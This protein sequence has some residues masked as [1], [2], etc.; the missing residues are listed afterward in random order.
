MRIAQNVREVSESKIRRISAMAEGMHDVSRLYFGESNMGT[1]DFIKEAGKRAIDDDHTFYTHNAGYLELRETLSQKIA[2]LRG[3]HYDPHT[4]IALTAGGVMGLFL[5]IFTLLEPGDKAVVISP[6]WPNA[7]AIVETIGATALEVALRAEAEGYVL[8]R[9]E[10]TRAL[11]AGPR[12]IVLSS[13]SNPTGWVA[14]PDDLA[15]LYGQARSRGIA[16]LS[17]EVYDHAPS[18]AVLDKDKST[19]L[20]VNSF[21]K[22]YCM[23]GWRLGYVAGNAE[24]V[25]QIVKLL[26]FTVSHATSITQRAAITALRNGDGFIREMQQEYRRKRDLAYEALASIASLDAKKPRGA[27]YIFPKV[28]GLRD[29]FR[30]AKELLLERGVG[31]APG[32]AF[33]LGGE[34]HIRLCFAVDDDLLLRAASTIRARLEEGR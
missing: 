3:I 10:L 16:V 1:P 28:E 4:E 22:T 2:E 25:A 20:V 12:L 14:T 27:F 31:V 33:G 17:D 30:F 6:V 34:G 5:V 7:K 32:A 26:E 29:S 21:S 23:T 18:I 24:V 19:V 15:W 9:D 8:D 13:P 11:D